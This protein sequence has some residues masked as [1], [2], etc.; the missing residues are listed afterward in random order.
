MTKI[1]KAIYETKLQIERADRELVELD[2]KL[3][4]L[5]NQLEMLE[6]I[7]DDEKWD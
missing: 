6:V 5:V 4:T 7:K 3:R 1:E 2:S